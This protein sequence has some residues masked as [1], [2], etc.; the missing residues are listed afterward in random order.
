MAVRTPVVTQLDQY[1]GIIHVRWT[2]LLNADSGGPIDYPD[3]PDRSIEIRGTVGVGG[4][5]QLEGSNF[6]APS[7]DADY[8]IMEDAQGVDIV[9]TAITDHDT[10]GDLA[11]WM[12][13]R[14]TAGD[15]TTNFT[16][17]MILRKARR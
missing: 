10:V 11:L 7:A 8:S 9:E 15:G 13:P 4:S 16:V 6:Q 17:D 14:V 12:R 3:Y 5:I 1:D 2:G